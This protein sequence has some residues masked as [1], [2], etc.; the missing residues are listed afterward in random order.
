MLLE[1][2]A[3]TELG[4]NATAKMNRATREARKLAIST[5]MQKFLRV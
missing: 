1:N 4:S 5:P 2:L 3:L